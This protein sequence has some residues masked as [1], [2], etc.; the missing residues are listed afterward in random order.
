[1]LVISKLNFPDKKQQLSNEYY[2]KLDSLLFTKGSKKSYTQELKVKDKK[3]D[4]PHN[5]LTKIN[6][7]KLY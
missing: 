7:M 6:L 1:M 2:K 3:R 5:V 4:I